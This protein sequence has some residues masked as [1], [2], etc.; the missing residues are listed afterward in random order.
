MVN[1]SDGVVGLYYLD[2][3]AFNAFDVVLGNL[4]PL[5]ITAF[6]LG[7]YDTKTTALYADFSFDINE[8][9]QFS[10]GGRYTKDERDVLVHRETFLGLGSEYFN[11]PDAISITAPL[12]G[13]VPV[14]TGSRS[15]SAF[16]LKS[17]YLSQ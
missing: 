7:D 16:I 3:N 1:R 15:D 12:E 2:S 6:T 13:L 9:W 17:F 14:F 4:H 10:I 11:N 8:Q 5:G